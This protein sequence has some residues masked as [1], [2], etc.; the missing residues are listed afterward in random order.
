M[1]SRRT[2][3]AM[4]ATL[5]AALAVLLLGGAA[6]FVT[7]GQGWAAL[8]WA[9]LVGVA[10]A[11]TSA[12]LV[13]FLRETDPDLVDEGGHVVVEAPSDPLPPATDRT[14]PWPFAWLAPALAE[15]FAGTP[16]VVL[17]N[18][19]SIL[20]RADLA[21]VRWQH[22]ATTHRLRH[23]YV[24]RFVP[25]GRPGVIRRTDE[26]RRLDAS[27]GPSGLGAQ[28]GVASG[29]QWG[30]TRRVEYG[31]GLDG[32]RRRVD[33]AFSTDEID[34]PVRAVMGMAGWRATLDAEAKGALV[35]GGLGLT[36]AVV[37]PAALVVRSLLD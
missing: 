11:V 16:Y 29:R 10:I 23:T 14:H 13:G 9:L 2:K 4:F 15:A 7:D 32:F 5:I 19:S 25:T 33:Y 31:L 12:G 34:A 1:M 30:R 28:L 26:S 35:M 36:A 37:V 22:V 3:A 20:V 6:L 8:A 24:S 27:A 17:S 21:D 18:G